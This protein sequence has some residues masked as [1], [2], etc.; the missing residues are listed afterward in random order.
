MITIRSIS[1][2][3]YEQW[4]PLW[5][6]NTENKVAEAIT[7]NTWNA[8]CHKSR[9]VYGLGAFENGDMKAILHYV[10]HATTGSLKSVCYMQDLFV[11]EKFRGRGIAKEMLR[12]LEKIGKD[13]QWER[14]Y[15]IAAE[16]NTAAQ[17]LYKH[18]GFKLDFSFYVLPIR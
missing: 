18:I 5:L 13:H 2:Q 16:S 17:R 10:L 3:D 8:L 15:W 11:H 9:P 14:I 7:Q 4:L 6:S 1:R 12:Q